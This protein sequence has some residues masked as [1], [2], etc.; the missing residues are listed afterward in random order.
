MISVALSSG[1][2]FHTRLYSASVSQA[3]FEWQSLPQSLVEENLT[4]HWRGLFWRE[5]PPP[6]KTKQ[7]LTLLVLRLFLSRVRTRSLAQTA[8]WTLELTSLEVS[9]YLKVY[10]TFLCIGPWQII[11]IVFVYTTTFNCCVFAVSTLFQKQRHKNLNYYFLLLLQTPL[12]HT[13]HNHC[14]VFW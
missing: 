6:A 13:E 4:W 1:I 8:N 10:Y 7:R 11:T 5:A 9:T 3:P 14:T 2:S 12:Q